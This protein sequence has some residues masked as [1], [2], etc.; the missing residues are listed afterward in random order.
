[1]TAPGRTPPRRAVLFD[2]DGVLL[3]SAAAVSV[4]IAAVA[5]CATG[6]RH[7]PADLPPD[8]LTLPRCDVLAQLGVEDP[9][10]ACERLWDGALAAAAPPALFPGVL[11]GL[12]TLRA[13]GVAVGVV[14]LQDRHRLGWLLPSGAADLFDVVIARG[15]AASKPAPDGVHAALDY[16]GVHPQHAAL[17]GDSPGDVL[18]ARRAGV[19]A[20]GAAWGYNQPATLLQAGALHILR[21]PASIGTPLLEHLSRRG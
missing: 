16:L 1:M 6:R 19:L 20:L 12:Q 5:T 2:L 13:A 15:D 11:D 8:A 10:A 17:L 21:A 14:T 9:D 7:T 3:D 4:T 18:A